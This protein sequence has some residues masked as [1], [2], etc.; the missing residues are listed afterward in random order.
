M[1]KSFKNPLML[2]IRENGVIVGIS[3][4][5]I[6]C[7][8]LYLMHVGLIDGNQEYISHGVR[9]AT[10]YF[11]IL[12]GKTQGCKYLYLWGARP[13]LPDRLTKYKAG[14]GGEFVENL[15]SSK[16]YLWLGVNEQLSAAKEFLL[17][18]PFMQ[19]K[20]EFVLE[21]YNS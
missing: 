7:E 4:I 1:W 2:A 18:N 5:R 15:V 16:E 13:F 14:L 12:E 3:F 11:G 8:I 9:G 10:Y 19:V 21:K 20:K 6:S 17:R